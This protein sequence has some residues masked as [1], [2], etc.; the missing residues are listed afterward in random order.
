MIKALNK[1]GLEETYLNV[2]KVINKK[3]TENI[4]LNGKKLSFPGRLGGL[5]G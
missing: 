5:V 1:V 2:M 3:L 4:I